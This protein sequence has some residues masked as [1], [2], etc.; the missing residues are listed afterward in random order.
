[1]KTYSTSSNKG[2]TLLEILLVIAAIGILAAIVLVA[3]NP[4]RQLAQTRNAQ[5]RS[6]VSVISNAIAQRILDDATN[7]PANTIN[8]AMVSG[9]TYA[10]GTIAAVGTSNAVGTQT[11]ATFTGGSP[12]PS[13]MLNLTSGNA[14]V[15]PNQVAGIPND[16][17][18]GNASCTGYTVRR[19]DDRIT[20]SAPKTE[21][22]GTDPI[23]I[24]SV[25]R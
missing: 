4:N 12:A 9:T 19:N 6:D 5:R 17:S 14:A 2:F 10:I 1:M 20:V 3:I 18:G 13:L 23:V 15:V 8:A 21:Q 25:S 22:V 11:C 16:P 24:I 7:L